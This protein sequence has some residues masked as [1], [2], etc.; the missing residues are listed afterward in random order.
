M[1]AA[2]AAATYAGISLP[3][4]A[5]GQP[6]AASL[7]YP[8]G[9]LWGCATA[10]YQIEGG[11]QAD[12]RGPSV[13]DTFSHTAG[14]TYRGETGDVAD[15]SYHLYKEDVK[16]LKNL[17]VSV[18]RMSVSWSRVFPDGTGAAEPQG[19]RLLQPRRRRAAREQHHAIRHAVS[20]GPA[21]GAA[22]RL[23]IARHVEG[24]CGLCGLRGEAL[25]ATACTTL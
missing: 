11:A 25:S 5:F 18:Y 1:S 16:L 9:F 6:K 3:K 12:G 17:G 24:L 23:A 22:R 14:K 20:L 10:A 21:A 13:W 8:K 2:A 19:P 4:I 7:T 15:D